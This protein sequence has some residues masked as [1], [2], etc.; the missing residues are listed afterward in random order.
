M[1]TIQHLLVRM[2]GMGYVFYLCTYIHK[3]RRKKDERNRVVFSDKWSWY[4]L[5]SS[6]SLLTLSNRFFF[7]IYH[8]KMCV[9]IT[10]TYKHVHTMSYF[11]LVALLCWFIS[12][13]ALFYHSFS[14]LICLVLDVIT[15]FFFWCAYVCVHP[16][17]CVF[18]L[19]RVFC[20]FSLQNSDFVNLR[21]CFR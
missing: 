4:L 19:S 2:K 16:D 10:L 1:K 17:D 15:L 7:S 18:V 9:A 14:L 20:R 13:S 21:F 11:V 8:L 5:F 12:F 6:S 3:K